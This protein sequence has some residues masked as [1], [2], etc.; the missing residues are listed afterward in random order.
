MIRF[1]WLWASLAG[2]CLV[3]LITCNVWLFFVR[4]SSALV[5]YRS[6]LLLALGISAFGG[7]AIYGFVKAHDTRGC[8]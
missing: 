5:L 4:D 2:L 8:D 7:V 1:R 3:G 6:E